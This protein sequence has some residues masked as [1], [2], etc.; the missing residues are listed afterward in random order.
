[1]YG[2]VAWLEQAIACFLAQDYQGPHEM[3]VVN[4]CPAQTLVG[5]FPKVRIVNLGFRPESLGE[6]RNL[7]VMDA[8]GD[9]IV[10]ADSDDIFL[11]N[12]LSNFAAHCDGNDWIWLTPQFWI[13]GEDIKSVVPGACPLFSYT[14]KAWHDVGRYPSLTVGEDAGLI[15]KITEKFKGQKVQL[16]LDKIS[17]GYRWGDGNYHVSGE[18]HDRAGMK[19]AH[20]RARLALEDR[21]RHGHE[22]T[23][24]IKLKPNLPQDWRWKANDYLTNHTDD[25]QKKT[26]A[27][28]ELGRFGDICNILPIAQHIAETYAKPHL[29]VSKE[30]ASLL[31]GC[32]YVEPYP[33]DLK[34]AQINEALAIANREFKFVVNCQIWGQNFEIVKQCASYNRES[35]RMAGFAHKFDDKDWRP[36][37]DRRDAGREEALWRKLDNGKPMVLVNLTKS[38]S[39]PYKGTDTM[40]FIKESRPQFNVVDVADL[41]LHRIYDLVG[42]IERAACVISIDTAMLHLSAA[43]DTRVVAII[44]AAVWLGSEVRCKP[45]SVATYAT[46]TREFVLHGIDLAVSE[47]VPA[48][49]PPQVVTAPERK[50][51]HCVERHTESNPKEQVRK[52]IAQVSWDVLYADGVVPAHMWNYPRNALSIGDIRPLP[53]LKDLLRFGMDQAGDDDI[54]FWT[55][56]DNY[57]HKDLADLLRFHV[58]V[59]DVCTSQRIE[60]KNSSFPSTPKPPHIW[61][62]FD[63]GHMGRDLFAATKRWLL[64]HWEELPDFILGASDFDLCLA[65]MVR[66]HFNIEP[67]RANIEGTMWP[68]EIERGYVAHQYHTPKWR[69]PDN[70]HSGAAQR[71]NRDK[72]RVWAKDRLPNLIFNADGCI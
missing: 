11:P 20:E 17:F 40:M 22:K 54:I 29:I 28:V 19:T 53:F 13:L 47:I 21:I 15:S 34:N 68:A 38:V 8:L 62:E 56:D 39:S 31:E 24:V 51:I 37:F 52:A 9:W 58:A 63:S 59:Y 67:T 60:F 43:T 3:L 45:V 4:S 72:F 14:K 23:G 25:S 16:P 26:V 2:G 18:G 33:V 1:V 71:W 49:K 57:L 42:L 70:I 32:S 36:V 66:R 48:F 41:V 5:E 10:I 30:F 55:N 64:K 46:V 12:H 27:I 65:C 61:K 6:L 35:W 7:C 44:N 69:D 50:L